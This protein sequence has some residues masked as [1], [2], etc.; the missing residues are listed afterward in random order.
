[1]TPAQ[2]TDAA[3]GRLVPTIH[4]ELAFVPAPPPPALELTPRLVHLLDRA[5]TSL[6]A[7]GSIGRFVPNPHLLVFPYLVREAVLSSRIEGTVSTVA[8]V[9]AAEA[10]QLELLET[11]DVREVQ[12]YIRAHEYGLERINSLPLSLRLIRE[13]HA[14]L[15][16]G[17]RGGG[18]TP[19]ELR[20]SQNFL[21]PPGASIR[22]ATYVPPPPHEMLD[23]LHQLEGFMH[24]TELPPLVHAAILHYQFEAIHPFRDGNGRV[25]RLLISLFLCARD[26]LPQPL[27]HLSA[28]FERTR[29]DYYRL[30]LRVSTHGDWEAWIGYFL[31]GVR[32]QASEALEDAQRL[33]ELRERYRRTLGESGA[34]ASAQRLVDRLFTNPYITVRDAVEYLGVSDPTARAAIRDLED[35]GIL[36]E[37]SGRRWRRVLIAAE[38]LAMLRGGEARRPSP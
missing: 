21:G 31:E 23:A 3:P 12:N 35:R 4:G 33:L 17:V 34:R 18:E 11:Q 8:D 2:F 22:D 1:M 7:L 19:G 9:F 13:L 36:E 10:G 24:D 5:A 30:L 28:F 37:I 26:L 6:G 38:L 29:S 25:G 27:L 14:R 20:N 15:M 32:A 16:D